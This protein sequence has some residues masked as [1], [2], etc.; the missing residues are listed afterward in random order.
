MKLQKQNWSFSNAPKYPR[1]NW[2]HYKLRDNSSP[3]ILLSKNWPLSIH[4]LFVRGVRWVLYMYLHAKQ[5]DH[6]RGTPCILD[7]PWHIWCWAAHLRL[8]FAP[9][10]YLNNYYKVSKLS[11]YGPYFVYWSIEK[12]FIDLWERKRRFLWLNYSSQLN[13]I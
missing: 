12:V 2:Q 9:Y 8:D 10:D 4:F 1:Y 11:L 3:F 7:S 5:E 13:Y 6:F